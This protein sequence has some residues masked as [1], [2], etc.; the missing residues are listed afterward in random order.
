MFY[1]YVCGLIGLFIAWDVWKRTHSALRALSLLL[2]STILA[3]IAAPLWLA[4]RPLLEGEIRE[5]GVAWNVVK[6][7]V[8]TWT[9]IVFLWGLVHLFNLTG[10]ARYVRMTAFDVMLEIGMIAAAWFIPAGAAVIIGFFVKKSI[11][12]HGPRWEPD[13][14]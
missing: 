12:E 5:G 6:Y 7:F 14:E 4:H 1:F 3:P 10:S 2:G 9:V 8:F 11:A 13:M